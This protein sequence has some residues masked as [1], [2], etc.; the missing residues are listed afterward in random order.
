MPP[1]GEG[2]R[3]ILVVAEA[4]G[5]SEDEQGI[6]LIGKAGQRL[7]EELK[8]LGVDLD[9]DCRKTNAVI[10]RPPEN[11]TP[12]LKEVQCCQEF[13]WAEIRR[14]KP[15]VIILL[16]GTALSAVLGS[17]WTEGVGSISRW[18]GWNIPD[19]KLGA[20]ICPTFHSSYVLRQEEAYPDTASP[21]F[22][23]DL[24]RAVF[25]A[26]KPL[27]NLPPECES[28]ILLEREQEVLRVISQLQRHGR[29]P[30]AVD[31]E[32]TGLYPDE[33]HRIITAAL[34]D[35]ESRAYAFTVTKGVRPALAALM[36]N[37]EIL[38][39]GSNLKFEALWSREYLRVKMGGWYWDTMLAAHV[40]DNRHE[41]TGL[42]FQTYVH[43]GIAGYED[44]VRP[45][46][47]AGSD[48]FNR[49]RDM[50]R[51]KLLLYNGMDALFS[52]W[53]ALEQSFAMGV[54]GFRHG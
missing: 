47:E 52:Y 26:N 10:C 49:L 34:C 22:R 1:S 16:G 42:K 17:I 36:E 39:V 50:P 12:T 14:S 24:Q 44:E 46:M 5:R 38:K 41:V 45:Y 43:F 11:R 13:L 33:G 2:K 51:D 29:L 6:Q 18:R 4:P 48:G 23:R 32:T 19:R 30:V 8:S 40:L 7:R 27:P 54:K 28:V 3:Q 9:R 15:K 35:R 53:L 21:L 31:F 37:P 20:W 25:K